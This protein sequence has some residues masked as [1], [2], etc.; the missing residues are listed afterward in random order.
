MAYDVQQPAREERSL[1]DLFA[2]LTREITTLVRQEMDLA[3]TEMGRK[4]A[5][6]GQNVGLLAAG[7]AVAYGGFLAILAALIFMLDQAGLSLWAAALL[8]G[9]VVAAI[10]GLLAMKG[11]S[12]LKET[13]L[14]PRETLETIKGDAQAIRR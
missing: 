9:V 14:I 3:K 13:D 12:A 8:V 10:G 6:I 11:L 7:G 1:G 4:A 5:R 2:D